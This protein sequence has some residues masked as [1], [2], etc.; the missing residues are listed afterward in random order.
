MVISCPRK[1]CEFHSPKG[2][3][4]RS[5]PTL[6]IDDDIYH[7]CPTLLL[8]T[9]DKFARL[10][11][12]PQT[13]ALFGRVN[14]YC[15]K[16]GYLTP[17]DRSH[18]ASHRPGKGQSLIHVRDCPPF[19]PPELIIQDE[20]HLISGPLGT[21]AGTYESAFDILFS[22]DGRY[23]KVIGST[24]TIR[25]ASEQVLDLFDRIAHDHAKRVGLRDDGKTKNDHLRDMLAEAKLFF[26]T[27]LR[28]TVGELAAYLAA[29]PVR[30]E[31][32]LVVAGAPPAANTILSFVE[33]K[34]AN[35]HNGQW[36][37]FLQPP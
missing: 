22:K 11:W 3:P 26:E 18:P 25:R 9:A 17:D 33:D 34:F 30:G 6:L 36:G 1:E 10:P 2:R 37:L 32:V 7:F 15:P 27:V 28:G 16:H 31:V 4:D 12:K 21:V 35:L 5:I 14:R 8:A 13:M 20:L 29:H 24:A 19:L 23:P